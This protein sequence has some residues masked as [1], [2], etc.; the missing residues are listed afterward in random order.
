MTIIIEG[1]Q[2]LLVII[3]VVGMSLECD[4]Q[5]V[6]PFFGVLQY[7]LKTSLKMNAF[8]SIDRYMQ[9]TSFGGKQ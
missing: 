1:I 7:L 5:W 3:I 8:S 6:M 2:F 4:I 9:I